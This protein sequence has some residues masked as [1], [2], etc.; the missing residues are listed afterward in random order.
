MKL[1][2]DKEFFVTAVSSAAQSMDLPDVYI[3]KDYWVTRSLKQ[4]SESNVFESVVFK[5]GTSLSKAY[6][7]IHRFSEDIDLAVVAD[8]LGDAK[9]KKLLKDT[10]VVAS[11][12]LEPLPDDERES[13]GSKFRKTVY[14]YPR[15]TDDGEFGQAS[16]EL[17]IEVNTFTTPEPWERKPIQSMIA[18]M[19]IKEGRQDLVKQ[20]ELE[21]FELNVLSVQRTLIEKLL[22]IIKDSYFEDPVTRL[23]NRIR[24][25][26]DVCMILKSSGN[27]DFVASEKFGELCQRC[28]ADEI[29]SWGEDQT[30]CLKKPLK[31]APLFHRF[32]EWWP[33]MEST[34]T[35]IFAD[36]VYGELPSYEEIRETLDFIH[37]ELIKTKL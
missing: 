24:H 10:E 37:Q 26:Y 15:N 9:R 27:R 12:G 22:G 5:G 1:H 7:L 13:K 23:N 2:E 16:P 32:E 35:N 28:I 17:L 18:E 33:G 8:G 29:E 6:G 25:I 11:E 4:L 3:E 21:P 20:Y 14:R 19:L 31:N 36:L 30:A 34:Y